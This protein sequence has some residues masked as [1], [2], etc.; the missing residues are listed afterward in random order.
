[1]VVLTLSPLTEKPHPSHP[2]GKLIPPAHNIP[3]A[4]K[5][6]QLQNGGRTH[7]LE[8]PCTRKKKLQNYLNRRKILF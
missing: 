6:N 8:F 7:R 3:S 5:I 2:S 1:M 4:T